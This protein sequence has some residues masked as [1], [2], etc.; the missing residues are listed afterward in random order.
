MIKQVRTKAVEI[1][2]ILAFRLS[3]TWLANSLTRNIYEI[4]LKKSGVTVVDGISLYGAETAEG[5]VLYTPDY[6]KNV[7]KVMDEIVTQGDIFVDIGASIGY[8][9]LQIA[10]N[11][12]KEGH[13]YAFEP[14][15]ER[16]ATLK[17]NI[18]I[19]DCNN[20]TP[21]NAAVTDKNDNVS[22]IERGDS[23][24]VVQGVRLE[25]KLETSPDI[26]KIDTEGHE[27][28]TLR[29]MENY[30]REHK[31]D[32]ICELHPNK[33][34]R[35][36]GTPEELSNLLEQYDYKKY[37]I[38]ESGLKPTENIRNSREHYL[39][40]PSTQHCNDLIDSNA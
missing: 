37:I 33:I 3:G 40:S 21:I 1:S 26:I 30:L 20:I 39:F 32:I 38:S 16:F 9:S 36:E 7:M 35:F 28:K 2:N 29:G 13:V 23:S 19:N 5:M 4:L 31:T 18:N 11:I 12:G 6:E 25:Q 15:P 8:F 14:A 22:I 24:Q 27:L 17:K 10:K 34:M